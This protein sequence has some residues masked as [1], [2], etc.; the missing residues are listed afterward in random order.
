[1]SIRSSRRL[2]ITTIVVTTIFLL[3]GLHHRERLIGPLNRDEISQADVE[4]PERQQSDH[5]NASSN[6]T[7]V[8]VLEPSK[9][10]SSE[11]DSS[12]KS[13][14]GEMA[15][16]KSD[17]HLELVVASVKA[18]DT[19]WFHTYLPSWHKNIYVADDPLAPLTVPRNKG[20]EAMVYLTYIIDRYDTLPHAT[21]FVH[22]SRFAWHND[23]PDYDALPT[24]QNFRL[25]Y[26]R[27]QGYVNLRC[28]WT[29][30][31]PAEIRPAVDGEERDNAEKIQAKHIYKQAFE[32]LL[33][34]TDVP[35]VVAVSC[36]SQFGV[37]RDTIRSRT[38]EEYVRWRE[39]L[40]NTEL[41]DALN[42]RVFE[43]A[44]HIIFG[45][46]AVHCPSAA[47]C[48]CNVFGLCDI[49]S[50]KDSGCEGRY[51]LPPYSTL[52]NGWPLVGWEQEERNF[53]GPL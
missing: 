7:T 28:V 37:T 4:Q 38:R 45:K 12:A 19:T 40:L 25:P 11:G 1:M 22:A 27:E 31:C 3:L 49:S 24:L 29:I 35:E 50:C 36:C 16:S 5:E 51:V 6:P 39:W 23:D 41:D 48:Y 26:L 18:E 46:E 20:R 43:F 42:G 21:L 15:P 8:V 17:H 13:G 30:G 34:G 10:S 33:P 9:P 2:L 47:D 53:T 44:W 32:E 14:G 52:P